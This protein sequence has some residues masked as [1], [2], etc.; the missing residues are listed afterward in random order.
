MYNAE[1]KERYIEEKSKEV[2]VPEYYLNN[3]F[4]NISVAEKEYGKDA[5]NFTKSEI[6]EYYK[7]LNVHSF[8]SLTVI[9][10]TYS[11]YTQWCLQQNLVVD[12]QNHYLEIDTDTILSCLNKAVMKLKIVS[13][14]TILEWI[15]PLANPKDQFVILGLFEGIYGDNFCELVNLRPED[16]DGNTLHLCTGRSIEVSDTLISIIDDC[17]KETNLYLGDNAAPRVVP[18]VYNG[19]VIKDHPKSSDNTSAFGKGRRIYTSISK[20]L[21]S[22]DA[23]SYMN[24]KD[25]IESGKIHMILEKAKEYNMSPKDYLY[26]PHLKEVEER[27]NCFIVKSVYM[28]KY[29]DYLV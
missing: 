1:L 7:S 24:A 17:I 5:S 4:K 14:E 15:K 18:A 11:Q 13:R 9:N 8:E 28:K 25:I 20:I 16:V 12:N 21:K 27:F 26:S 3:K 29:S 10:S 2:V 23:Y 6:I 22:L 19:Y